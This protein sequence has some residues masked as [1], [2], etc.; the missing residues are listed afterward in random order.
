[1]TEKPDEPLDPKSETTEPAVP[2]SDESAVDD[3]AGS[4]PENSSVALEAATEDGLPEW[5]PLTPELVEDE[6]IRGEFV[7][8]W[9]VVGLALLLGVS[10]IAETRTLIHLKN[11]QYLTSHG[12]L[13][14]ANDVFSYTANDRKW[15]NLP[16]LFDI[17]MA[18]V[19]SIGGGI[20]LSIVQ[21]LITCLA[22]GLLAH[23]V[24]PS[25][26][27]WWGSI[28]AVL[29]LLACYLQFTIQPEL[30]SLLGVSF[31]L[32]VLVQS[33][34]PG[35]SSRLW[36]LVPALWLWAQ[37]DQ[38]AWLGWFLLLLWT[39][40]ER[41]SRESASDGGKSLL[42][43]VTFASLIAVAV[44]P[45]LWESWLAPVRTYL[46]DYPAMRAAYPQPAMSDVGIY[47][48]W[49]E[50]LW[51]TINHRTIAALF[52][53]A[54]TIVTVILNW[55][56]LRM[57]HLFA[58]IGFNGLSALATHELA[59][60]SFVNCVVCTVNAQVW[61]RRRFGQVYSI[62]WRELL[63]SRG[64]RAVT[65]LSFFALAWLILSGRL[66]GPGGKRTGLG[67]E[68]Q[69]SIAMN[70]YQ[71]LGTSL[72]DDHP[73]NF[74]MRQGDLMI[75]GGQKTFVDSRAG[76]FHGSDDK[77]ILSVHQQV[78]AAL[79]NKH[80]GMEGTGDSS[81][82]QDAF[83]KYQIRQAWPRMNGPSPPPDYTSFF[84]LL[85]S[86]E[87]KLSS[88]NS[89][90]AVFVRSIPSDET[91][92]AYV[93]DHPF[94][95][96]E[97]AFRT[98]PS[99]VEDQTREFAKAATTYDNI[100]SLRRPSVPSGV[101]SAQHY[102]QLAFQLA[103]AGGSAL[104]PKPCAAA[105]LSVR[106]AN[107]GLRNDPNSADGY[108]VL[109]LA[110]SFLGQVES[111][112]LAQGGPMVPNKF[113]YYQ[114]VA[115]LQQ[116]LILT[117]DDAGLLRQ[118]LQNYEV[119]GRV[120]IRLELLRRLEQLQQSAGV[121]TDAQRQD[122][123]KMIEAI[124][125]LEETTGRIDNMVANYLSN[126]ADR[127]QIATGAYQAG[128]ILAAIKVLEEDAI[129]L[130]KNPLAKLSL[131]S[132]LMEAGRCRE[133][134]EAFESLEGFA[135]DNS[136]A[137]WRDPAALSALTAAN[138]NRSIRLWSE[139]ARATVELNL[140]PTLSTLPFATLN[141]MWRSPDSY[142]IANVGAT[143]QLLRGVRLEGVVLQY[144]IAIA[145]MES[146]AI[147][148]AA[149]AIQTALELNPKS[150]YRPLIRFYLECLTGEKIEL[151]AAEPGVEELTDIFEPEANQDKK[152]EESSEA[153]PEAKPESKPA[154]ESEVKPESKSEPKPETKSE[155]DVEP[156]SESKPDPKPE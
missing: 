92:M 28:C 16:W 3:H 79:R 154:A 24:R 155:P 78:R 90:T 134:A 46:I 80:S 64:G 93:K 110:Y 132:W 129:Y 119:M 114:A 99:A 138:Y 12:F 116:A 98:K 20:G 71:N 124:A 150:P 48:I 27:T 95:P 14:S 56:H 47:P 102:L 126:G 83:A 75:W 85:A 81:V 86:S 66:D 89:S 67:F 105:L 34:E 77:N 141:P 97:L 135:T 62:D 137:A 149:K 9:V 74:S 45:F 148:D 65:V 142:P 54:A 22:F 19:Y 72:I 7:I 15:I 108:R 68:N 118:L 147:D 156:K 41:L 8:R 87:F 36:S 88:L 55:S 1:M 57:S 103:S 39:A 91:A 23:A 136:F 73:F 30:I 38:R 60:A 42:A 82:W 33:E 104:A 128:G 43:K 122:R 144:Q 107:E 100:F 109:G 63:F 143:A 151:N 120:D 49:R 94:D 152:T 125:A 58:L 50:F 11:G 52:L 17:V 130:A 59:A 139:Q 13:P 25:I 40:G 146:G 21:G 76:L 18:G 51:E 70:D 112:I 53:F 4:V 115:A 32:W 111:Q 44:H 140:M 133:A 127:H 101:L 145:Q 69:L 2:N 10:Q 113:R 37:C 26:R 131:G 117:P 123:E 96:V 153:K 84:D 5:E 61:Y 31:V 121:P 6:A 29:A 106:E 35:Q